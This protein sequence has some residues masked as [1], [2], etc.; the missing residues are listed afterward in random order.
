MNTL[1]KIIE[2][3][4]TEVKERE[5]LYPI[6]LLQQSKYFKSPTVSLAA[7]LKRAD[8][9]GIIAEFKKQSPSAGV[10]N[11]YL[12]VEKTSIGYMQ[13]G[14]SALSI[15]T[16]KT[17]FGGSSDDL[18]TARKYNFCPILRKDFTISEY[19]IIEAKS[20]G[21]DAILLIAAV[22][23][24][25]E[26]IQF[27]D[28]AHKLKLEVLLELHHP[29]ELVKLYD[30]VD[31]VGVNNRDL[32]TMKIDIQQS[33]IMADLI[34]KHMIKVSESGIEN[35]HEII[36]L[37]AAGYNGFLIGSHFM[38]QPHPHLACKEFIEQLNKVSHAES[39]TISN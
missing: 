35:I 32:N 7:Y 20:I 24:K 39:N 36:K 6:E 19:Q 22:L 31:V 4:R 18:T 3:K 14:A 23:T 17:F 12:S 15:L 1:Q 34:P 9:S 13:A 2:H 8:K 21:A 38:K 37:K 28:A 27:T 26:I 16:D 10:I 30:Q 25:E 29:D 11:K 5:A 33:F